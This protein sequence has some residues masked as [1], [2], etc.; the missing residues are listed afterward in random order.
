MLKALDK[1]KN[2]L[3]NSQISSL[4][5]YRNKH[6][7]QVFHIKRCQS[8]QWWWWSHLF[9][10]PSLAFP[11]VRSCSPLWLADRSYWNQTGN[12]CRQKQTFH[13]T[14]ACATGPVCIPSNQC[15]RWL[16]RRSISERPPSSPA[17]PRSTNHTV[18]ARDPVTLPYITARVRARS[19]SVI[20]LP[21]SEEG[22]HFNCTDYANL[23]TGD[24]PRLM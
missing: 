14:W 22:S 1:W 24:H 6:T 5:W 4:N 17:S 13:V 23:V 20:I 12:Q 19:I 9:W 7:N 16:A 21:C 11:R 10:W 3:L 18:T 2:Q 15:P 8:S